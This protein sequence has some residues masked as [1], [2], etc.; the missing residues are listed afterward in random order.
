MRN[1]YC[2]LPATAGGG[3][4]AVQ[5]YS[6]YPSPHRMKNVYARHAARV[7]LLERHSAKLHDDMRSIAREAE[8]RSVEHGKLVMYTVMCKLLA[9]GY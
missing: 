7:A 9:L 8:H 3:L 1:A 5:K 4:N 2:R 6:V